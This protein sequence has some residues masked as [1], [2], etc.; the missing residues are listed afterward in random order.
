MRAYRGTRVVVDHNQWLYFSQRFGLN[1]TGFMESKPGL[2]PTTRHLR[3]LIKDM[4]V[5]EVK[6]ILL[7]AYFD[8]RHARF[9]AKH[10]NAKVVNMAHQWVLGR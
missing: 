6:L 8:P 10:T 2:P 1:M 9:L 5:Q 4:R 7:G 3:A